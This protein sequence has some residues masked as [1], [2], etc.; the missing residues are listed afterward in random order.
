MGAGSMQFGLGAAGSV[1]A[2]PVLR[3][4]ELFLHDVNEEALSLVERACRD[5]VEQRRL[6]VTVS[7]STD[8]AE[9]LAGATFV[10][11]SIEVPPRFELWEQ[12]F[13]LPL[14]YGSTQVFGENGGPGGFFHAA[15]VIPPILEICADVAKHCPKALVI[16]F[17]N[18][19]SRVCLAVHRRFPELKFV[20]LCHEIKFAEIHLPKVLGVP[21]EEIEL[22][23]GGLNHFGAMLD[24]RERRTGRDLYPEIRR[25]APDYLRSLEGIHDVRLVS[26]VLQRYGF[27]PY[28]YDSHFGEYL[29]WA[30]V[31]ADLE[32]IARFKSA[33]VA[34]STA[35]AK[36]LRRLIRK[37]KGARLVKPD[38][39]RAVPIVEAVLTD[40]GAPEL[41]VNLPNAGRKLAANLPQDLVVEAPAVVDADGVH[42]VPLGEIPRGLAALMRA[43]AGVQDLVVEAILRESKDLAL[44]ALLADGNSPPPPACERMLEEM[45]RVQAP[46]LK[47]G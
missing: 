39:E 34:N 36:R 5:A 32:G 19:M 33:Y 28:T 17:S 31:V 29:P 43:E 2:S 45:L 35:E 12:D 13:V 47:L 15:R 25:R 30:R 41:S 16:N 18:P 24:V 8:R 14:R 26:Y 6:D 44:Q 7:A 37:G 40:A 3:D 42:G 38:D 1:L 27:L 11:N 20:G 21:F 4:A 23:A 22:K 46:H 9:A 10:I